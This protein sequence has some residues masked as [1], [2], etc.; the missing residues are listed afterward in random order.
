MRCLAVYLLQHKVTQMLR[1]VSGEERVDQTKYIGEC[2]QE[3]VSKTNIR[4]AASSAKIAKQS[5]QKHDSWCKTF[6]A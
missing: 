3:N 1:N 6:K 4:S 5:A 2:F